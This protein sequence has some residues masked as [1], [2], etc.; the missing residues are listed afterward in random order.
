MVKGRFKTH[1][2]N[3]LTHRPQIQKNTLPEDKIQLHVYWV[4]DILK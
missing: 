1:Y 2:A 3:S 4:D